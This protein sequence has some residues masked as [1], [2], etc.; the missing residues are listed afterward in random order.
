VPQH[1]GAEVLHH[2]ISAIATLTTTE[3]LIDVWR[4]R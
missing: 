4:T 2:T 1:Y 3:E